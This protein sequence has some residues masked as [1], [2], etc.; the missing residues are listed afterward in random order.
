MGYNSK[1]KN[2]LSDGSYYQSHGKN[3]FIGEKD[4]IEDGKG[5]ERVDKLFNTEHAKLG[6]HERRKGVDSINFPVGCSLK[7]TFE[8]TFKKGDDLYESKH[9]DNAN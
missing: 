8:S 2:S 3:S 6:G 5:L 9:N 4:R 7:N 1:R